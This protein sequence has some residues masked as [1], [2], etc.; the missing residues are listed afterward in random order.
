MRVEDINEQKVA[1]VLTWLATT[2]GDY[3]EAK[4]NLE[5]A[6]ILRKRIRARHF[7]TSEG[8]V[9]ERQAEAE[10]ADETQA[11]DDAYISALG[12][13]ENLKAKRQRGDLIIDVY[14]TL[15]ASRRV[16]MTL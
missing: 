1:D 3:A 16:G 6:E 12:K 13:F 5:S 15:A 4:A 11:A 2:D 8:T 7:L 9:T 10:I 14:R